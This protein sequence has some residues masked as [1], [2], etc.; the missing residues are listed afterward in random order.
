MTQ[1]PKN[2]RECRQQEEL[3]PS[4]TARSTPSQTSCGTAALYYGAPT[5]RCSPDGQCGSGVRARVSVLDKG[6]RGGD[7]TFPSTLP[8]RTDSAGRTKVKKVKQGNRCIMD[9]F[10]ESRAVHAK[11]EDT[12]QNTA[13][14]LTKRGS[15][16]TTGGGLLLNGD[17]KR[18]VLVTHYCS[19]TFCCGVK[20]HLV[21]R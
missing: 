16:S 21:S 19:I 20:A 14:P 2:C 18:T 12:R 1:G 3:Y 4:Q 9:S 7:N 8:L 5:I 10:R 15:R 6:G 13:W 17:A 11:E